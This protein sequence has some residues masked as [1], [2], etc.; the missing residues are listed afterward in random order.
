[1]VEILLLCHHKNVAVRWLFIPLRSKL[2][3]KHVHIFL[4]KRNLKFLR[5]WHGKKNLS[6][7][8]SAVVIQQFEKVACSCSNSQTLVLESRK[9]NT[10]QARHCH[11]YKQS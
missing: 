1:M 6:S 2:V 9:D 8:V 4:Q 3:G 5:R 7:G 10:G 11:I